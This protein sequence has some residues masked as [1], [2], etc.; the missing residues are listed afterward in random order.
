M[1]SNRRLRQLPAAL[2]TLFSAAPLHRKIAAALFVMAAVFVVWHKP[3]STEIQGMVRQI[4]DGDTVTV[5]EANGQANK[6]RLAFIDAPERAQ[7]G[8]L[9]A[10]N[11]LQA[12]VAGRRVRVEIFEQDR[13]W[14]SVGQLWLDGRDINLE[15]LATGHAWHYPQYARDK[16][17]AAEYGRYQAAEQQARRNHIGLWQGHAEAPW[18]WRARQRAAVD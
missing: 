17:T 4:A 2:M 18:R 5:V 9:A 12:A 8:G 16:Q 1:R 3:D 15:L 10:R 14:R 13:Y 6:I 7:A 11:A